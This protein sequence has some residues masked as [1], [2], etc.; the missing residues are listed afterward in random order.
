M[1]E[2]LKNNEQYNQTDIGFCSAQFKPLRSEGGICCPNCKTTVTSIYELCP[3]CGYRLHNSHCT[4]C[5]APMSEED[6]YCGECG[7]YSKGTPCP[8]C[9]TLCFRSFCPNCNMPVDEL[10][11]DELEKAKVDPLFNRIC[12]LAEKIIA[13]SEN[14]NLIE[15]EEASLS[16]EILSLLQRY[17]S[18]QDNISDGMNNH[19]DHRSAVFNSELD[20]ESPEARI[21]LSDSG[22]DIPDISSAIEEL[23]EMIKSMVPDP[24]LTPQMQRNYYSARKVAVY[25]KSI[26]REPIGWVCNLCGCHH[27]SPSECARPEL[28]GTWIYQ[29]KEITTK[30]YE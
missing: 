11:R 19:E 3:H 25:R 5:G 4:Y 10:G 28:G 7:G 12:A 14:E 2:K 15:L 1:V 29:D 24:G 17:G 6:L 22:D 27:G 8:S 13:A 16:P 30:T 20:T 23:N 9:G 26:V 18:M 21:V